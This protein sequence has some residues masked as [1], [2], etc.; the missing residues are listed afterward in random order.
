MVY[1]AI[2]IAIAIAISNS[3]SITITAS[4]SQRVRNSHSN[5]WFFVLWL[6]ASVR[7]DYAKGH[8]VPNASIPNRA[9]IPDWAGAQAHEW[10]GNGII[11]TAVPV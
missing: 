10:T 6:E 11:P 5:A 4:E 9:A 2:S 7:Q 8:V 3:I 1:N